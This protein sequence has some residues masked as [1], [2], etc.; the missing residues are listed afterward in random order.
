MKFAHSLLLVVYLARNVSLFCI[1]MEENF[2]REELM[3]SKV[4]RI[5]VS[6]LSLAILFLA[7]NA[8]VAQ[9]K[10]VIKTP[11]TEGLPFS[12]GIVAGNTLYVAGQQGTDD[13]GKLPAGGIGPETEATLKNIEKI[14][15]AAGFEL[16]DVVAV[17]VY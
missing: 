10:R 2:V 5:A 4:T 1:S 6:S 8:A 17:T 3:K 11:G 7:V 16:K 13:S 15:K 12:D 9:D 14:L